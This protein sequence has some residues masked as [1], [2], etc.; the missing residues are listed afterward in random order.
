MATELPLK[1]VVRR[2][3]P[4]LSVGTSLML[5][6]VFIAVAFIYLLLERPQTAMR[7]LL[8]IGK[9]LFAV[10]L[11]LG[12]VLLALARGISRLFGKRRT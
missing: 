2:G 7:I 6:G 5:F 11:I 3:L 10:L 12:K 9:A 4:V 1:N 8:G